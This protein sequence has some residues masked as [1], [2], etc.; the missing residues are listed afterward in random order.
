MPKVLYYV[1]IAGLV[2]CLVDIYKGQM[3]E[4]HYTITAFYHSITIMSIAVLLLNYAR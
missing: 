4:P 1:P 3:P 2:V